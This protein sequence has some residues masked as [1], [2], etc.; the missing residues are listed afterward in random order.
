MGNEIPLEAHAD[1]NKYI[2]DGRQFLKNQ[3]IEAAIQSFEKA[4]AI[5]GNAPE[6]SFVLAK[7]LQVAGK[8][9]KIDV[10]YK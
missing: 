1:F 4:F 6:L 9:D 7:L 5:K 10:Y 3:A 2:N 8:P